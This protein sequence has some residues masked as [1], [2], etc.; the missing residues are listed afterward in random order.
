MP[1]V[2][3][4]LRTLLV[5]VAPTATEDET[6]FHERG[7]MVYPQV[8]E[9]RQES[10]EKVLIIHD[11]YHL[12]LKKASILASRLLLR[13]VTDE[14]VAERYVDG[15][16]YERHLYK[17]ASKHASLMLKPQGSDYIVVSAPLMYL[18]SYR[19]FGQSRETREA[20]PDSFGVELHFISDYNHTMHFGNSNEDRIAYVTL[21]MNSV[22][23]RL[24]QLTPQVPIG[25]TTIQGTFKENEPYVEL[26][27]NGDLIG[28]ET[29]K[30][31]NEVVKNDSSYKKA[32][33]VY[34]ATATEMI[35]LIPGGKS[36]YIAGTAGQSRACSDERGAVGEDKPDKF[37]GVST[38]AH[39]IGHLLGA[40]DDGYES[41]GKCST[42]DGYVMS[43]YTRG[44]HEYSFSECSKKAIAEFLTRNDSSCLKESNTSCHIVSLPNKAV[45]LPGYVMDG[46]TFCKQFYRGF[47]SAYYLELYHFLSKCRISCLV[48]E[49]KTKK[50]RLETTF[51]VDGM[52][53]SKDNPFKCW[54]P[55]SKAHASDSWQDIL[56][57]NKAIFIAGK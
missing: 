7:V 5:A 35:S 51:A 55:H 43:K 6:H 52:R 37:T 28:N 36:S 17:D 29:L 42:G 19:A 47:E 22:S 45:K 56:R 10:S 1:F 21:F 24:N 12:N 13:D 33:A 38:A 50:L 34:L 49:K 57:D 16:Y 44:K 11:G 23:L 40:P 30:K 3:F 14:G 39:E 25:L 8:L 27:T 18:F 4:F 9:D 41:A 46:D 15:A 31:L 32:D 53:C 26:W 48:V 20:I 54:V 2:A